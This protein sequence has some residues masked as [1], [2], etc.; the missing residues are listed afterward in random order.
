MGGTSVPKPVMSTGGG[1][2]LMCQVTSMVPVVP[3]SASTPVVSLTPPGA[4]SVQMSTTI[5]VTL[6]PSTVQC[7]NQRLAGLF[8]EYLRHTGDEGLFPAVRA[9][10]K[11]HS[12]QRDSEV[13]VL[14]C[15]ATR[16]DGTVRRVEDR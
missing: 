15:D 5:A 7:P 3:V 11:V 2:T 6:A 4:H 9:C 13:G 16:A 10:P 12:V 1:K 14:D 8:E